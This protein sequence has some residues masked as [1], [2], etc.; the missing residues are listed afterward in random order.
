MYKIAV[1]PEEKRI[2]MFYWENAR[3]IA[4]KIRDEYDKPNEEAY[5]RKFIDKLV[6]KY[7]RPDFMEPYIKKTV[8]IKFNY[9]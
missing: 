3:K 4:A 5:H 2:A 9:N 1:T 6:K 8:S 7:V